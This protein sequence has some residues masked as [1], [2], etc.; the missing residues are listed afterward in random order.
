MAKNHPDLLDFESELQHI[1]VALRFDIDHIRKIVKEIQSG[2]KTVE[3]ELI[4][5]SRIPTHEND[6]QE[7]INVWY[8]VYKQLNSLKCLFHWS[9]DSW[10][11]WSYLICRFNEFMESFSKD[12]NSQYKI[13]ENMLGEMD[14]LYADLAKYFCKIPII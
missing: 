10:C 14:G 1:D 3:S 5:I 9:I 11:V 13:A 12:A 2:V 4:E 8:N 7:K 6:R